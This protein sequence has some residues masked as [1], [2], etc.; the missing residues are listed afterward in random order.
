M[1]ETQRSSKLAGIG[2]LALSVSVEPGRCT[3]RCDPVAAA[4]SYTKHTW[5]VRARVSICVCVC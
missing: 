5:H 2:L 4:S 1:T 3:V